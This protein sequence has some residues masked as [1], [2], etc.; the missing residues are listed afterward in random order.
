[1]TTTTIL[2]PAPPSTEAKA[3]ARLRVSG[4]RVGF[5]KDGELRRVVH[6]LSFELA[7]GEC[8]AIVGESGSGKSVSARSLVGLTGANAVVEADELSLDGQDLLSFSGRDW[9]R[10]RGA[11]VGFV[12]Q[13][14]LVS[15]D[16]LRP[17]GQEI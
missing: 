8:V 12:L 4:L 6:G 16:P 9:R 3:P 5:R 17:V 10:V 15:L 14:A 13:D 1:M 2:D 7:P 11:Q